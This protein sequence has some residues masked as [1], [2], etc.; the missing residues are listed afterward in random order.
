MVWRLV[1]GVVLV[2]GCSGDLRVTAQAVVWVAGDACDRLVN[3]AKYRADFAARDPECVPST[4][5]DA[6]GNGSGSCITWRGCRRRVTCFFDCE[7]L[8]TCP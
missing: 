3:G 7:T 2:S 4:V 1:V 8:E 5:H 6:D